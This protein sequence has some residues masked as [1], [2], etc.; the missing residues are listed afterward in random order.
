MRTKTMHAYWVG[1]LGCGLMFTTQLAK[2]ADA[3]PAV[4][5]GSEAAILTPKAAP[6]P[7]INGA[8]VFGVRPGKPLL[9]TVAATGDRPMLYSAAGLPSGL[10]LDPQTGRLTGV[11]AQPGEYV[12]TL[13]AQNALGK[14]ERKLKIVCG[15]QIGLTPAMGWNSW[16]CFGAAVTAEKVKAAAD[17]MASSG[18]INHGWAYINIDDFW[19]VNANRARQDPTLAGPARDE[20]G[21]VLTNPRFPD[22][23]GLVDYIHGLGLKAGIYSSPGPTT[24]GGCTGSYQH[25]EQDVQSY[26]EWGID[27][28]KYDWCSYGT[29]A[30]REAAA[31]IAATN[32][33]PEGAAAAATTNAPGRG[34][35]RGRGP[36]LT[37]E[38]HMKPYRLMGE[39]LVKAPRDIIYSLC[40]YGNDRVWEWGAQVNGNSWRTSGDISDNWR[41]LSGNGFRLGGHEAYVG[42][43]HFDDPDMMVLGWV[44]VGSGRNLHP[45]RLTPDEQYTHMSLWCLLASPLLL[46]CDL[47]RLDE[48]TL[49]LLTNDEVLDV[50][51]DPLGQQASPVFRDSD[52]LIEV[53]AKALEDGSKAVGLF[54]RSEND[55]TVTAKW[56]DLKLTGRA[57]VRDLWRQ[58]DVG[59]FE[60]DFHTTVPRHGVV[61]VKVSP[62]K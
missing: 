36:Q 8:K 47:T 6:T 25:E 19:E 11:I 40:Q 48:F 61:L 4:P 30:N 49:S 34:G 52:A 2:A 46:G 60:G 31:R 28:L 22:M 62:A 56:S 18:L 3:A 45:A 53:W 51:Q 16:N 33:S 57:T 44:D 42:P 35:G 32:T 26:V 43:G 20:A 29:I 39:I 9:F 1:L 24:C 12:V 54:N 58:K 41:S 14:A 23:K 27:Y 38:E 7:R 15:S 59:T 13:G 37:R 50:D 21:R 55:T 10:K 17:A 5:A